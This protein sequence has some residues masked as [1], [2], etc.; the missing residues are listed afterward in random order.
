[1]NEESLLSFAGVLDQELLGG[2][3]GG[4]MLPLEQLTRANRELVDDTLRVMSLT[5]SYM[6]GAASLDASLAGHGNPAYAYLL[7]SRLGDLYVEKERYQDAASV[8]RAFVARDP[9]N[10]HAPDLAMHAIDAYTKG[11]FTDLVIEGKRD[12]VEHYALRFHGPVLEGQGTRRLP[13]GRQGAADQSAGPRDVL[14]C[15]GAEIEAPD[16]LQPGG[17]LV[18]RLPHLLP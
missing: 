10:I 9:Q 3:Q 11:G 15:H 18:P 17:T 2:V 13:R 7:Y 5:Y 16:G 1:M 14:P 12:Y 4:P 8:Y 6:D